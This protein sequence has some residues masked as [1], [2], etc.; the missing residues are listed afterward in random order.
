MKS[1]PRGCQAFSFVCRL[2]TFGRLRGPVGVNQALLSLAA[3]IAGVSWGCGQS[4]QPGGAG[5]SQ[6]ETDIVE[7]DVAVADPDLERAPTLQGTQLGLVEDGDA[8]RVQGAAGAISPGGIQ[9]QVDNSNSAA[10]AVQGTV[11]DDGSFSVV[12]DG[13]LADQ[14]SV[15]AM[16]SG[17]SSRTLSLNGEGEVIGERSVEE[18]QTDAVFVPP[19]GD[20]DILFVIDNSNSMQEEQ[21]TLARE[22]PRMVRILASGDRDED[23]DNDD[24]GDFEPLTSLRLGVVSSNMGA[25]GNAVPGCMGPGDDGVLLERGSGDFPGCRDSYPSYLD[26]DATGSAAQ[27]GDDFSCVALVGVSGCGL[28]Q[29]LEAGLKALVR[30]DSTVLDDDGEPRPIRFSGDTAGHGDGLNSGFVRPHSVLVVM[31]V[32]DEDDCS[33]P[34]S[35]RELFSLEATGAYAEEP[36]NLRCGNHMN[37]GTLQPVERYAQ[38][39]K[40]LRINVPERVVFGTISGVPPELDAALGRGELSASDLIDHEGMQ[41]VADGNPWEA[42]ALPVPSC[43]SASGTAFPPNRIVQTAALFNDPDGFQNGIVRSIC[44]DDFR[45]AVDDVIARVAALVK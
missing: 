17:T 27:L 15:R 32:T 5:D 38:G 33:I 4:H 11:A 7:D 18:S 20:V 8:V 41:F 30:S 14:F 6:T 40:R 31:V 22:L 43:E 19:T 1:A 44:V 42:D 35:S 16:L 26:L 12:V 37:D 2:D 39:L 25:N 3:L 21:E 45:P 28:E 23:G 10:P 9:V 34:D 29:Q 24:E 36:L 13:T